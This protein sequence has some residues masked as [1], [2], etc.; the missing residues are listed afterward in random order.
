M[1][2]IDIKLDPDV[3]TKITGLLLRLYTC[4]YI[5]LLDCAM[6]AWQNGFTIHQKV[7]H[8]S[9]VETYG[10]YNTD[11]IISIKMPCGSIVEYKNLYELPNYDV[12]CPCG[13]PNHKILELTTEVR[14]E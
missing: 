4:N 11:G 3:E 10:H 5:Q 2:A 6:S 8:D 9:M 12:M 14:N 13:N 7:L 1:N